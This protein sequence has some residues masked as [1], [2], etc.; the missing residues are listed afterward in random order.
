MSTTRRQQRS[1]GA[2]QRYAG[3]ELEAYEFEH[4]QPAVVVP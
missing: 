4:A 1:A 2:D 3:N